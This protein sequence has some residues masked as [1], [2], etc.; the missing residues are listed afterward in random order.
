[1]AAD[2]AAWL[3]SEAR[4]LLPSDIGVFD[5]SPS[6]IPP[7]RYV[8]LSG[9]NGLRE[10][11]GIDGRSRDLNVT[12]Y[13]YS[14]VSRKESQASGGA[15]TRWVARKLRDHFTDAL[16]DV[17]GVLF[18]QIQHTDSTEPAPDNDVTDRPTVFITDQFK[19]L[20]DLL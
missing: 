11:S 15:M 4:A 20:G 5:T 7:V 8:V 1:M 13:W 6:G 16:P 10:S 3:L 9:S 18:G 19:V 14:V 12:F 2:L 17:D